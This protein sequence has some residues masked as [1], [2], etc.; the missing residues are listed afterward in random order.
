MRCGPC[1][2]KLRVSW[3]RQTSIN[4]T[5]KLTG[6]HNVMSAERKATGHQR[7]SDAD[8]DKGELGGVRRAGRGEEGGAG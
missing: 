6:S 5:P 2:T 4:S 8:W 7:V 1:P 3:G